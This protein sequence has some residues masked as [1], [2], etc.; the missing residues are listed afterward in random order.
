[1]LSWYQ[2]CETSWPV[3][4]VS[5]E[6]SCLKKGQNLNLQFHFF[7]DCPHCSVVLQ[8]VS[9]KAVPALTGHPSGLVWVL[10]T[11]YMQ[12]GRI[13]RRACCAVCDSLSLQG[14]LWYRGR[15]KKM[16]SNKC[17]RLCSSMSH[18]VLSSPSASSQWLWIVSRGLFHIACKVSLALS[19]ICHVLALT[20]QPNFPPYHQ[21]CRERSCYSAFP[22]AGS[23][24]WVV[25]SLL[26]SPDIFLQ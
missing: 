5:E 19:Q 1:M 13:C 16:K 24:T 10:R 3:K 6:L 25:W 2:L 7:L 17:C 9:G 8:P 18:W 23:V 11:T 14:D 12:V 15:N 20:G 26:A 21:D 4:Q 22:T